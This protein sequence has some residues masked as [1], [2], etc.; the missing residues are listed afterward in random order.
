M[1]LFLADQQ[2]HQLLPPKSSR[3]LFYQAD[4]FIDVLYLYELVQLD[5]DALV[6]PLTSFSFLKMYSGTF[7]SLSC[8][9]LYLYPLR[10]I[11]VLNL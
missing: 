1:F 4:I 11:R 8:V 6:V 9:C 10:L 7:L 3:I 5:C 2:Q